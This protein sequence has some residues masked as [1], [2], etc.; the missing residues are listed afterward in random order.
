MSSL[1]LLDVYAYK[2]LC[3]KGI[4]AFYSVGYVVQK[5]VQMKNIQAR[6]LLCFAHAT[7]CTVAQSHGSLFVLLEYF[8]FVVPFICLRIHFICPILLLLLLSSSRSKS[9]KSNEKEMFCAQKLGSNF[10]RIH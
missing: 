9:R 1:F 8:I 6:I 2:L 5:V 7:S 4:V 3:I 10:Q